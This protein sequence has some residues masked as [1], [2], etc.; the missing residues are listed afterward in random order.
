VTVNAHVSWGLGIGIQHGRDGDCL[1]QWGSN[2]GSKGIMAIYPQRRLSVVVLANSATAS[3]LVADV[4]AR[5]IGGKAFW[6]TAP[7]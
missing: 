4:A 7:P 3:D 1:W 2:P 5:A 6:S